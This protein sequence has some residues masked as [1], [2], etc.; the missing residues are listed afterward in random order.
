MGGDYTFPIILNEVENYTSV[1]TTFYENEKVG[2][3]GGGG[4]RSWGCNYSWR[5]AFVAC[6]PFP[7]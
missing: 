1:L 7:L 2:R 3:R 4:G 5:E 6:L